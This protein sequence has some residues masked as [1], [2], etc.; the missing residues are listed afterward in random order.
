MKEPRHTCFGSQRD[1]PSGAFLDAFR[2]VRKVEQGES[3]RIRQGLDELKGVNRCECREVC[4]CR[5]WAS[6]F[7]GKGSCSFRERK[8]WPVGSPSNS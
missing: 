6:D 1:A 2:Q 8:K 7:L 5:L 3:L 4:E